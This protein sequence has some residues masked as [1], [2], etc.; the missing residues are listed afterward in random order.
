MLIRPFPSQTNSS[1]SPPTAPPPATQPTQRNATA[2]S[3]PSTTTAEVSVSATTVEVKG[4]TLHETGSKPTDDKLADDGAGV[5][6]R[7]TQVQIDEEVKEKFAGMSE[8]GGP[9]ALELE[10]GR[11]VAMKRGVRENMFRVI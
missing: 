1:K 4:P 2:D 3:R 9:A 7:K 11:P 10:N 6:V 8:E 5:V